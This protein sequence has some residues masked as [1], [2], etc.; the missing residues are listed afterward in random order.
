MAKND[1]K[2]TDNPK[3]MQKQLSDGNYSL[4]LDYYLGR[5]NVE[6]PETGE[7]TSK[8][9]R[10]REY[11]KLT[12]YATPRTPIERQS[13]KETLELAKKIRFEREQQLK[14]GLQGYRLKKE[15]GI[16]FLIFF[17]SY[18]NKRTKKDKRMVKGAMCRFNDFLNEHYPLFSK[19]LKPSQITPKMVEEFVEYL[20]SRNSGEGANS[21]YKKFKMSLKAAYE[22]GIIRKNPST[23][24]T[25]TIDRDILRKD[26]LSTEEIQSLIKTAYPEQNKEVRRA[27]IFCLYTGIR[28][29]DVIDLKYSNIDYSNKQLRFEQSKTKGN[30]SKSGVEIPLNAG[31]LSLIGDHPVNSE[32]DFIDGCI[33]HLPSHTMCLKALRSWTKKAGITKHITWHC[34]RHS[35]AVNILNNGANIK[36]VAGLLGHSGL[37]MTEKYTRVV[38]KLKEDAINS[39]PELTIDQHV[40]YQ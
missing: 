4:Y 29:C 9:Q 3:L 7:I 32:G 33:F 37:A 6:D 8:V 16:N 10:K 15:D 31:L 35:F 26:V 34:A 11:L 2:V 30:S 22:E 12:L 24:I 25:C 23:G 28:F 27:F 38:D 13:N 20:Q 39:L 40:P 21:Y 17:Q 1:S 36:T 5:A 18:Y 14:E 19:F